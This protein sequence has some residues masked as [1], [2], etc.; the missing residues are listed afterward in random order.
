MKTCP[1]CA[2]VYDDD[3]LFCL[4]DGNTLVNESG[5]QE[6][7]ISN[8]VRFSD[9]GKGQA[10]ELMT[11]CPACSLPNR[12]NSK[13]CKKCGTLLAAVN[14]PG[15]PV[16]APVGQ[17]FDFGIGAENPPIQPSQ[18]RYDETRVFQSPV[19]T[20]PPVSGPQYAAASSGRNQTNILIA[21][22]VLLAAAIIGGAVIYS[23]SGPD[24]S[25]ANSSSVTNNKPASNS[26]SANANR[27]VT[28]A[29]ANA[30]NAPVQ[31]T[32]PVSPLVGRTGR[33]TT[34]QNIRTESNKNA[35]S[36]GVHYQGARIEVLDERSYTTDDGTLATWYRVKVLENGCDQMTGMGCGN[37][38]YGMP[39]Q[40][41]R[42]GWMN[43]R[44]II[45]D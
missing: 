4:S 35:E 12:A 41:A 26:P 8:R 29:A 17:P 3:Y 2:T 43:A 42:E 10:T 19:F 40:A 27:S 23:S 1:Q 38:L 21:V 16:N 24:K 37:D 30:R 28:N 14:V 45:L 5:E 33:L 9:M 6:T 44:N 39:G 18:N 13:F 36:L 32:A 20:P 22:C 7:L 15:S 31:N 25:A 34:N 11:A